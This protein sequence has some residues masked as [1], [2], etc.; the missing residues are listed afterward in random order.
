MNNHYILYVN[1]ALLMMLIILGTSRLQLA[2]VNAW[3][4]VISECE[5]P[6]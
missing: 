6:L 1:A 5:R 2:C 4:G 3:M